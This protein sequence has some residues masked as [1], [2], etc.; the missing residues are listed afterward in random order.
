[1]YYGR[2]ASLWSL[3]FN[4]AR[5]LAW[6]LPVSSWGC[7]TTRAA[8]VVYNLEHQAPPKALPIRPAAGW[9]PRFPVKGTSAPHPLGSAAPPNAPGA[10][11]VPRR[12]PGAAQQVRA[13]PSTY[14]R[15]VLKSRCCSSPSSSS[16]SV[17][18]S[19]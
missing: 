7:N 1:M 2:P 3:R 12:G 15:G 14:L 4:E 18:E 17:S 10:G 9:L 19:G 8:S 13:R 16:S 5:A 11:L 6:R